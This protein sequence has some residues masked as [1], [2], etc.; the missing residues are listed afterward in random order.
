[1]AKEKDQTQTDDNDEREDMTGT[2]APADDKP[3]VKEDTVSTAKAVKTSSDFDKKMDEEGVEGDEPEPAPSAKAGDEDTAGKKEAKADKGAKTKGDDKDSAEDVEA[4][5]DADADKGDKA[6]ESKISKEVATRAANLGLT[7]EEIQ[8]FGTDED[9]TRT[10]NV[11]DGIIADSGTEEQATTTQ[12]PAG[13]KDK[14]AEVKD[15]GFKLEFKNEADIDPELLANIKGMQKHYADQVKALREQLEGLTGNIQQRQQAEFMAQFDG[16][17]TALGPDFTDTFGEGP[18]QQL[19]NRTNAAKNRVAVRTRMYAFAKGLSDAGERV[20]DT[21][22]LFDMAVNSL[23]GQKI[24]TIAGTKM[25]EKT[26][27]RAKQAIGRPATRR[28]GNLTPIQKAVET[29]KK[30]DDLI[31][32]SED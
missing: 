26:T 1:M 18:S 2:A 7:P 28:T 13:T 15:D 14:A 23:H 17:I 21:Q 25:Q 10:L 24:K 29:S 30:F 12:Q 11:L 32:T 8:G 6:P 4:D 19:S 20:P 31:N 3:A 9:L 16:M 27:A 5:Q 22:Q